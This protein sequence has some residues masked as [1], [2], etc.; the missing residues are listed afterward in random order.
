MS[1]LARSAS[2][3]GTQAIRRIIRKSHDTELSRM[4][5]GIREA[6]AYG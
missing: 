5:S 3:G 2:M 1:K 6:A 4:M